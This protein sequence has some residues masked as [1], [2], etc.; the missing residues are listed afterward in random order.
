MELIEILSGEAIRFVSVGAAKGPKLYGINLVRAFQEKYGFLIAPKTIEEFDLSKGVTFTHGY[1]RDEFVIDKIQVFNNGLLVNG[2]LDTDVC[3]AFIDDVLDWGSIA[4]LKFE[5]ST[6]LRIYNSALEINLTRDIAHTLDRYSSVGSHI[7]RMIAGYG[8]P[9]TPLEGSGLTLWGNY[10]G[11]GPNP[12][13]LERRV[14]KPFSSNAY[15][16]A[17]PLTTQHHLEILREIETAIA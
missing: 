1:F 2:K 10:Q 6:G 13:K 7:G 17:A 3:D 8:G 16:S 4:A 14:G 9:D 5:Q 15:F 11:S 12:Y